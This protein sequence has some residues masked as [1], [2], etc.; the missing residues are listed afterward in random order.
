MKTEQNI[1]DLLSLKPDFIGFIFYPKS[2]RYVGKDAALKK[3]IKNANNGCTQKVGVFVNETIETV[4]A[5]VNDYGLDYVQ[6][7]GDESG[8]FC[9]SIYQHNIKIINKYKI[10]NH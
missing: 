3:F 1:N 4:I 8:S 9:Q 5:Q 2:K 6:L 7:H 10:L